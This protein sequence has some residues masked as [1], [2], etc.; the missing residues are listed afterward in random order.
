MG[1]NQEIVA[2]GNPLCIAV[3]DEKEIRFENLF[4]SEQYADFLKQNSVVG[5]N[6][7]I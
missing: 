3:C 6:L 4:A 2:S 1:N 5:M 7:G